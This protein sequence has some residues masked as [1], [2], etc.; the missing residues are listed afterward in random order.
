MSDTCAGRL[1]TTN[2]YKY[3]KCIK[4]QCRRVRSKKFLRWKA[5]TTN[6]ICSACSNCAPKKGALV[7]GGPNSEEYSGSS[8]I[9]GSTNSRITWRAK[10][11]ISDSF[12]LIWCLLFHA[13]ESFCLFVHQLI[14]K[15]NIH[16][17]WLNKG[18]EN[19]KQTET[20]K[21]VRYS[22][23]RFLHQQVK[24]LGCPNDIQ[25]FHELSCVCVYYISL[26]TFKMYIHIGVVHTCCYCKQQKNL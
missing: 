18:Q 7:I 14:S 25:S 21:P 12:G 8:C 4:C 17:A 1:W 15:L 26:H 10:R 5:N 16:D 20:W 24:K 9:A 3:D 11:G 22:K 6:G 23:S 13:P 2:D 19:S